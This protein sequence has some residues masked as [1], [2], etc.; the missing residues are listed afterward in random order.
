MFNK[1]RTVLKNPRMGIAYLRFRMNPALSLHSKAKISGFTGFSEYWGTFL[2]QPSHEELDFLKQTIMTG[3]LVVDV[4]ANIGVFSMGVMRQS[5]TTKVIAFEPS[6]FNYSRLAVNLR[7]NK[8]DACLCQKALSSHEASTVMKFAETKDSP[9]TMHFA[10]IG[11][12]DTIDVSVTT[13][14]AYCESENISEID[15][16]KIDV[17]GYECDVLL[18]AERM[19]RKGAIKHIYIEVCPENLSRTGNSVGNL[20]NTWEQFGYQAYYINGQICQLNDLQRI[21]LQN[22]VLRRGSI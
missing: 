6:P 20:W 18:G 21:R 16:L 11:D 4:G 3:A 10:E 7:H 14:D 19:L 9:S 8:V 5:P 2:N 13:L 15:L 17:E 22:I 12:R 1:I